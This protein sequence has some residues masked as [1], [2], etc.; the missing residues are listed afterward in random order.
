VKRRKDARKAL[1]GNFKPQYAT[2]LFQNISLA[3]ISQ[4][5]PVQVS[6]S[7]PRY[8]EKEESHGNSK[9]RRSKEGRR[10]EG[11]GKE[12]DNKRRHKEK[13]GQKKKDRSLATWLT[14]LALLVSVWT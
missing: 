5:N 9:E 8:S 12:T 2:E 4:A 7:W 11:W 1:F 13:V 6:D 3:P 14:E 10:E